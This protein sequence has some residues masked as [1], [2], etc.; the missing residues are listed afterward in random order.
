MAK[1][2]RL[3]RDAQREHLQSDVPDIDQPLSDWLH[4][5]ALRDLPVAAG[6]ARRKHGCLVELALQLD[7]ADRADMISVLESSLPPPRP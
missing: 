7:P 3:E 5:V 4:H 2:E 6:H 1:M